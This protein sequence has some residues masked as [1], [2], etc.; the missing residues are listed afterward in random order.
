LWL[1]LATTGLVLLIACANLAN[2]MLAR[3][4]AR[5]REIAVRLAIGAS[6]RSIVR[7]LVS[8]SLLIAVFG[9]AAGLVAASWFSR[10]LVAF[11]SD[12]GSALFV[13]LGVNGRVFGFTTVVA[14]AAALIFGLVPA[15]RATRMPPNATIKASSRSV[16]D[17]RERFGLRRVLVVTQVALS[18]VMVVGAL[19]FVR[20]LWKLTHLDPGFRQDGVVVASVDYGNAHLAQD[21]RREFNRQITERLRAIPG[22]TDVAR[23]FGAPLGGN[24]WNNQIVIG[25]A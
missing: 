19:L 23:V 10:S 9:A 5:E 24:F 13:D 1:M 21:Q 20:S 17:S 18:L 15:I 7:Q 2:L 22:V 14:A 25:G 8:E 11:L 4:T 16:T 6:R 12:D 3:A